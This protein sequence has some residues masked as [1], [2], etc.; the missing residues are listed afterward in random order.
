MVENFNINNITIVGAGVMGR[1][2]AQVALMAG[3]KKVFLY[4]RTQQTLDKAL[5][6]IEKG[7]K[8]ME[9]KSKL[10]RMLIL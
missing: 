1:E 5:N 9:S 10:L 7:L 2:I 8:K 4:S 6:F 3:F